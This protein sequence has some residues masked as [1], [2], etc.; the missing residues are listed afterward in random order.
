V[1]SLL[2]RFTT[3]TTTAGIGPQ[4]AHLT[5]RIQ[6]LLAG[7]AVATDPD[8]RTRAHATTAALIG[9]MAARAEVP[10]DH[11]HQREVLVDAAA[12]VLASTH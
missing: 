2:S 3:A 9:V 6:T 11:Q 4:L 7:S 12:A 5:T 1:V 10:L 8:L